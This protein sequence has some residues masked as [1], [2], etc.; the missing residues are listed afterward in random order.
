M[1]ELIK[2]LETE[3]GLILLESEIQYIEKLALKFSK[4]ND[5][6]LETCEGCEKRFDTEL[7]H[8]D[9]DGIWTCNKCVKDFLNEL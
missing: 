9:N 2:H 1:S 5:P 6:D 8:M 4:E 7:M 3:H